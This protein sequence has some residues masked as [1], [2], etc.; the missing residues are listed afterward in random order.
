[1]QFRDY[2]QILGVE[3]SASAEEIRKHYRQLARKYHPDVS[4]EKDAEARMKE[5]NEAYAVLKDPVKRAVWL[6]EAAGRSVGAET[7][8]RMPTDFLMQQMAWREAM[9]DACG[10]DEKN[11][12]RDEARGAADKVLEALSSA[13]DETHDWDK[14]VDLTRRLMFIERFLE[15]NAD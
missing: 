3:R 7:N 11:A 10:D 5:V 1:M 12:V 6:C 13:I 15:Q 2:Y 4:K 9:D 8:T 14:A